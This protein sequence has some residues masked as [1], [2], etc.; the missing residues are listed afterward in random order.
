MEKIPVLEVSGG[1]FGLQPYEISGNIIVPNYLEETYW[2]A[3]LHPKGVRFFERQWLVNLILWGNF[4]RLRDT[5]LAEIDRA[6]PGRTLQVACVY[7]DFTPTLAQRVKP[8]NGRLD[9]AEVAPVQ[10]EN[11]SRKLKDCDNVFLHHQDASALSFD[12]GT[13]DNTVLFF[14]LH[15]L[16]H[17]TRLRAIREAL[18]VT[19]P[20]GKVI[21]VD[22]HRP[23]RK[24]PFRYIMVPI[25]KTLEPYALDMWKKEIIDWVPEEMMPEEIRKTCYFGEL[26]QKVVMTR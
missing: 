17:Q 16:P 26:Y 10:L 9:V 7:G 4:T 5:A 8:G 3:Y 11:V 24:N 2:W 22:Y 14:L 12:D 15:E 6:N 25:L 18:R 20:G 23:L 1:S 19:R 13:F 21:F